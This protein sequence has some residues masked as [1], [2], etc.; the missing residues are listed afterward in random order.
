MNIEQRYPCV[1]DLK[2]RA[3]QRVPRFAYEYLIG[4][5]GRESC[6]TRNRT[7]LDKVILCP[8]YLTDQADDPDL[9]C[10]L[11]GKTYDLPFG[12]APIGM[13]GL[14]W[15]KTSEI[16][17]AAAK[18]NNLPCALSTFAT[19]S[20]EEI[21][22]IAGEHAWFQFYPPKDMA[23]RADLL[24]RARESGYDT[25]IVTVDIPTITRRDRDIRNGLS[26][27]PRLNLG[28]VLQILARPRW[29]LETLLAGQPE[30]KNLTP[31][32]PRGASMEQSAQFLADQVS[33]HVTPELLTEIRDQ[34]PGKLIV[35]GI[36]NP[37]DAETSKNI[38]VDALIVSNH[39][40]RQLDAA[41]SA[42]EAIAG[43]RKTVGSEMPLI[44]DGG[45]RNGLDVTRMLAMGA[46]FV[47]MG[48]PFVYAVAAL[49]AEGGEHIIEILRDEL[50]G[51]LSQLGC[52]NI[53]EIAAFNPEK[54]V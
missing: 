8:R 50:K 2:A 24:K 30:F 28:T 21:Q 49:G 38:G 10:T 34:W 39:G 27:P 46:D 41:I 25:L 36:L 40:G 26:I 53:H 47:L 44:A 5:I 20:L 23:I 35:K 42:I 16:L 9:R 11:L 14:I 4:G 31:Y 51:T 52:A 45:I 15:P 3:A 17:A 22:G 6:L 33:W 7:A 18:N 29:A 48:R 13:G 37:E 32:I 19:A 12:I 43:I 54:S 1:S